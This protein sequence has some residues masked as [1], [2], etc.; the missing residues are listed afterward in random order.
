[1]AAAFSVPAK[2]VETPQQFEEALTEGIE[3]ASKNKPMVI[4][5]ILEKYTGQKPSVV[6]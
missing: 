4:D 2:R 3:L 6:P 5:V 1:M